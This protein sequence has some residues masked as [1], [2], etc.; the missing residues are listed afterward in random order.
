MPFEAL[1]GMNEADVNG[2]YVFL[3]SLPPKPQG[4]R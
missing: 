1:A 2:M 4:S 3:K